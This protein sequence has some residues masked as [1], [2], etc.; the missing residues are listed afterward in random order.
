MKWL[1]KSLP[2]NNGSKIIKINAGQ[3]SCYDTQ[4]LPENKPCQSNSPRDFTEKQF[5]PRQFFHA[6]NMPVSHI[7]AP[8]LHWL[9]KQGYMHVLTSLLQRA[10]NHQ[11]NH[12]GLLIQSS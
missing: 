3:L 2:Q 1:K 12:I 9:K 4:A 7:E 10:V 8:L 5:W 11:N 6:H